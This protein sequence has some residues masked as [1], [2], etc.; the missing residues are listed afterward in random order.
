M[1]FIFSYNLVYLF[2]FSLYLLLLICHADVQVMGHRHSL[3]HGRRG[4]G[5]SALA[6]APTPRGHHKNWERPS[7]YWHIT[8]D[9]GGLGDFVSVQAA[10]DAVPENNVVNVI[11]HIHPGIYM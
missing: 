9:I 4:G 11:V 7:D 10:V 1:G 2:I 6:P 3:H 5:S 8:V